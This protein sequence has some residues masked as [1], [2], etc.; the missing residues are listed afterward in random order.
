M[1]SLHLTALARGVIYG[2]MS[3]D[4]QATSIEQQLAWAQTA[5]QRERV[6]ALRTFTDAGI[7]GHATGKRNGF[8]EM[9]LYCQDEARQGRPV[10]AI[11]C[12]HSNRFSRADSQETGWYLWEF[13]K[14]GV[15]KMLTSE[16]WIDFERMEDRVLLGIQ[17]DVSNHKYSVD[18]AHASTRGKLAN[19]RNDRW[20]GGRVPYG[21]R[22][23]LIDR[24][25]GRPEPDCLIPD[26]ET[27]A[28]VRWIFT[29]Y[30][31]GHG[32]LRQLA[33]QLHA[34]GVLTSS[35][36][37]KEGRAAKRWSAAALRNILTSEVY[38]G[39]LVWN[40]THQGRFLGVV[41]LELKSRPSRAGRAADHNDRAD[42]ICPDKDTHEPLVDLATFEACQRRLAAQRKITTPKRGGTDLVLTGMLTC[43]HCGRRLVGRHK[44][45]G[46]A[47]PI[48]MCGSYQAHGKG[49]CN[50]NSLPEAPLLGAIIRKLHAQFTPAFFARCEQVLLAKV[51]GEAVAPDAVGQTQRLLAQLEAQV[52][53]AARRVLTEDDEQLADLRA[54]LRELTGERDRQ[55]A[56]VE[57]LKRE[58]DHSRD[59]DPLADV[60]A[61]MAL[62]ARLDE[63]MAHATTGEKRAI[64]RDLV[65]HVEVWF[66]HEPI[67]GGAE[68]RCTFVRGLIWLPEGS[69]LATC[70]SM[71]HRSR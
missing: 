20:N 31:A 5:C 67:K 12:W 47:T 28:V 3:K 44:H 71:S 4:D 38:L 16:R 35:A 56:E 22:L 26:P 11:V 49:A 52:A 61:A 65:E 66:R 17:Q 10:D 48:Y 58:A 14:T 64:L 7:S 19:A 40:R 30:G 24:G 25:N 69:P 13:R 9:L 46:K 15:S 68:T 53:R 6:N 63:A 43:G 37:A 32:S 60:K 27:A 8:H 23:R 54:Q 57:R 45:G 62:V 50:F 21:Y 51:K 70:L 41:G 33:E 55:A 18:L 29:S 2:R 39:R 42:H 1:P 36:Y 34:R 59:A